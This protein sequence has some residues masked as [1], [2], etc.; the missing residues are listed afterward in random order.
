VPSSPSTSGK[1]VSDAE[2]AAGDGTPEDSDLG[3]QT[4]QMA[5]GD[6][7]E[8]TRRDVQ[9]PGIDGDRA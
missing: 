3:E 2:F 9:G 4:A 5:E 6:E 1:T 7:D 8:A